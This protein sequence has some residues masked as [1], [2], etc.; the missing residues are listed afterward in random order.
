MEDM[1]NED[2]LN[3]LSIE[4]KRKL[5]KQNGVVDNLL[6]ETATAKEEAYEG[7]NLDNMTSP[8]EDDIDDL[9][10]VEEPINEFETESINE[11]FP[12]GP[13]E[14]MVGLWKKTFPDCLVFAADVSGQIFV[15]R[16]ITRLEYKKLISLSI[17]QLQREEVIC[18]TCVLYPYNINWQDINGLRGGIPSTLASIIMENSGFSNEYGVQVL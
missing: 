9:Y 18:S 11:I 8:Y 15:A 13:N 6:E 4:A 16:S 5:D 17:D 7:V 12:G 1:Y 3:A 10:T 2:V 14:A